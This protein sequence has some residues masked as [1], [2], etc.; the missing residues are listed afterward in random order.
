MNQTVAAGGYPVPPEDLRWRAISV[1]DADLFLQSS[2]IGVDFF[3]KEALGR[4][5]KSFRDF[6]SILDFGCGC[7]RLIRSLRPLCDPWAAIHGADIDPAAIEWCKENID[8]AS[9][10]VNGEYP[11]LRFADSS[12]DLVYACSVFTH[13][14]AEHQFRWLA[15]L[16]RIMKPG[17]YLLMTFRHEHSIDQ[18]ADETIRERIRTEVNRDGIAF[19]TTDFW[20]GVFPP[21]YGEAYHTPEYVLKNWGSYFEV[22]HII[23]AGTVAQE[24]AVLR[25]RESTFLQRLFRQP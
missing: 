3:D 7:G 20:K 9:F 8:D 19:M 15:E 17:G 12:I 21:W 13:L 14:D 24:T 25:A 16:Q 4:D 6:S 10:S 22:R 2:R 18:I 1:R 11:P 23:T 5:R